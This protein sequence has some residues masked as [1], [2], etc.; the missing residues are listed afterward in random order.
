MCCSE[1][2][3]NKR[4]FAPFQLP[5]LS[6]KEFIYL[7]FSSSHLIITFIIYKKHSEVNPFFENL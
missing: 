7:L 1:A 4:L 5:E 6:V 2:L 3:F